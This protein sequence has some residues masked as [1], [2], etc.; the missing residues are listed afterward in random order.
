M[1]RFSSRITWLVLVVVLR[2]IQSTDHYQ[3][4]LIGFVPTILSR[5]TILSTPPPPPDHPPNQPVIHPSTTYSIGPILISL[6]NPHLPN[7][8][9]KKIL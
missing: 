5:V 8:L 1:L 2:L 6:N 4:S 3:E 9:S 7:T